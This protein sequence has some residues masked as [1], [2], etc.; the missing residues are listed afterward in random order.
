MSRSTRLMTLIL[1]LGGAALFGL[2]GRPAI[3]TA[4]AQSDPRTKAAPTERSEDQAAIRAA[5]QSFVK[6]FG[7]RD[8]KAL[9]SHWTGMGEYRNDNGRSV[10]GRDALEKGFTQLFAK[11]PEIQAE[12]HP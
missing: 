9:A 11:T 5:M 4:V 6:A 2:N 12:I 3:G 7:S 1:L 10:R 8:A